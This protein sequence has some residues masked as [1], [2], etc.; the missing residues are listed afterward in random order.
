MNSNR[1]L[2]MPGYMMCYSNCVACG[3][4]I[5]FNPNLVPSITH[6][7]SVERGFGVSPASS[8]GDGGDEMSEAA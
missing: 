2:G 5:S 8:R 1:G 6:R 4:F 7:R 3:R